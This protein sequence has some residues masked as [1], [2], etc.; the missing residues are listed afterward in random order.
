MG[1]VF[2]MK[3][4]MIGLFVLMVGV[5]LGLFAIQNGIENAELKEQ[6]ELLS[7]Q[8][9]SFKV[10]DYMKTSPMP[11]VGDAG[12]F[13]AEKDLIY[14]RTHY[15]DKKTCLFFLHELGHAKQWKVKDNC[16]YSSDL[17]ACE[18]GAEEFAK[19]NEWR[20]EGLE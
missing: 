2:R 13:I 20:C 3:F 12:R 4:F 9:D 5:C 7:R 18:S 10:L 16:F 6:N 8:V 1:E 17:Y 19:E 11:A 15:G 14:V